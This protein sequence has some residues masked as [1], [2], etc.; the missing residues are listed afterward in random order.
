MF[1]AIRPSPGERERSCPGDEIVPGADV[2]MDRAF[3]L[4][5]PPESVWPWLVQL[6]KDRAGWYLT[7]R[8]ERAIP[9]SR[10]ALRHIDPRWQD[11]AVGDVIPDWGGRNETFRVEIMEPPFALVH[12]S[13]R[14][15]THLSWAL[16]LTPLA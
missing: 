3:T 16:V 4:P 1:T 14:G 7:R 15:R 9:P 13:L 5:A 8:V 11:L 2:V 10:R 6:G 12:S